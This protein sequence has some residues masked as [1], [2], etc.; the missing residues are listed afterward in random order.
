MSRYAQPPFTTAA[1]PSV[2]HTIAT[3]GYYAFG[4][5]MAAVLQ[6]SRLVDNA[7]LPMLLAEGWRRQDL[8]WLFLGIM[9]VWTYVISAMWSSVAQGL[10]NPNGNF[11]DNQVCVEFG[12][13]VRSG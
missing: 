13:L 7:V 6:R 9:A 2:L 10:G 1:I 12:K 4:L 8:P 11:Y 5:L 3:P